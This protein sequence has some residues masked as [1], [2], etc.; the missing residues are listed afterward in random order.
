MHLGDLESKKLTE[1]YKLAKEYQIPYYSQMKKQELIYAIL[2]A[3]AEKDGLTFM[4]GVL[5]ILP[6]GFGFLSADQLP[7]LLGRYLHLRL[8]NPAI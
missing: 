2:K 6:E 3:Q 7:P 4:E 1:L 5:E 8:A